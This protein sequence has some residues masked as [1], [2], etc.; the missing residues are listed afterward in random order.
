M[1]ILSCRD[2]LGTE[3]VVRAATHAWTLYGFEFNENKRR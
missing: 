2:M 3:V 1:A